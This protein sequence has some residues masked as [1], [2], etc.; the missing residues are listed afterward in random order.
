MDNL[1]I[2]TYNAHKKRLKCFNETPKGIKRCLKCLPVI[3]Q[4]ILFSLAYLPHFLKNLPYDS[5]SSLAGRDEKGEFIVSYSR[6]LTYKKYALSFFTVFLT[7]IGLATSFFIFN[8]KISTVQA[9]ITCTEPYTVTVTA[10]ASD[11]TICKGASFTFSGYFRDSAPG[12]TCTTSTEYL[13][14]VNG[15][16]MTTSTPIKVSSGTYYG[17]SS[18]ETATW[19]KTVYGNSAGTQTIKF[20][21]VVPFPSEDYYDSLTKTITVNPLVSMP[22]SPE[23]SYLG[24]SSQT[25]SSITWSWEDISDEANYRVMDTGNNNKSGDLAANTVSWQENSLSANTQ[26]TRYLQ[27]QNSCNTD[28]T[29]N[30]SVY[31]SIESPTG[32]SFDSVGKN[33]ITVSS[34]GLI[35]NLASGTS[36]IYFTESATA[37]NS[38]WLQ[39]NTWEK[40]GLVANTEYTFDAKTRNGDSEENGAIAGEA[41]YTLAAAA[42]VTSDGTESAWTNDLNFTFTN[43]AGFGAGGVQYYRYVWNQNETYVFNDTETQWSSDTKEL[44]ATSEGSW[45]LHVKAY[46]GD[47]VAADAG[48]TLDLGPYKV[49]VTSPEVVNN[50]T[51]DDT[52]RNTAGTTY[53]VSFLSNGGAPLDYA[54]YA[55]GTSQGG[56]DILSWTNIYTDDATSYTTPWAVNFSGLQQGT[57]Y[58]SFRVYDTAGN[59][60]EVLND[61]FYVLKD[62]IPATV[63]NFDIDTTTFTAVVTWQ[64]DEA[65]KTQVAWGLTDS[66][67]N[68]T[69]EDSNLTTTH[70]A[71]LT[72]LSAGQTYYVKPVAKDRANNES[73]YS[74]QSF[75]TSTL[76]PT[77]ITNVQSEALSTTSVKVTWTTNHAAD[78]KVRYGLT[79]AYGSEI[80]DSNLTVSHSITITGLTAGSTYHYEVL[81]TGNTTTFDAD[82]TFATNEEAAEESEEE[83]YLASPT[84]IYPTDNSTVDTVLPTITGL[85]RSNNTIFIF[86][87]SDMIGTVLSTNH[88]SGTGSFAYKLKSN[89]NK[90]THTVYTIAR[91]TAGVYSERS[92]KITFT[93]D[94]PYITPTLLKPIFTDGDN[95]T[96]II[97]GV[98]YNDS[99]IKVYVDGEYVGEFNVTNSVSNNTA[100][101]AYTLPLS[102]LQEGSHSV[103]TQAFSSSG[104]ASR[105]SNAVDFIQEK[106]AV[107]SLPTVYQFASGVRYQAVAGDSLWK[108]AERF[109]GKGSD[110]TKIIEANKSVYPTLST[111]PGV[112]QIGWQLIIP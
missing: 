24:H 45:Y 36:G 93:V 76:E 29:D 7:F 62:T 3:F 19:S 90:G 80:Y 14:L 111:N 109:Y 20:R 74:S 59:Y 92:P 5:F 73:V 87:D 54:Q 34:K 50:Q 1:L 79:T 71:T 13:G 43:E 28:N 60:R 64:T 97:R 102:D 57:N 8:F 22:V 70:S 11:Q 52:W 72:G 95:P 18:P 108:I 86:I 101:F 10:P 103:T 104:E 48:A 42:D 2:K 98:A 89:L 106:S 16:A 63:S 37:T 51:G 30:R 15:S 65:T 67:G 44:T 68:T 100:S 56:S 4:E 40:S 31:T 38:G 27:A 78:S 66:L 85:A 32:L 81:S 21:V 55:I 61:G 9:A 110:Y 35:S 49:D 105:I 53:P 33:A 96:V 75:A 39:T 77:V 17:S 47:D 12:T 107:E 41:K 82:A 25:E 58:V 94:L 112:I 69:T 23:G 26:Y 83:V 46:N 84:L 6:Y 88:T 99:L 91:N